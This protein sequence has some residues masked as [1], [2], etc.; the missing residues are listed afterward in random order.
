MIAAGVWDEAG[1]LSWWRS[2]KEIKWTVL[3]LNY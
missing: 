2:V 1:G 3:S